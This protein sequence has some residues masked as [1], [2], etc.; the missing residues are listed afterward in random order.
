MPTTNTSHI[1]EISDSTSPTI[2]PPTKKSFPPTEENVLKLEHNCC[3]HF[4]NTA[5]SKSSKK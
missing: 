5:F 3:L 4:A 2:P 1:E